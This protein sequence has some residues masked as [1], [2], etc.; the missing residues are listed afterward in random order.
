MN[1]QI[2]PVFTSYDVLQY[3]LTA[4]YYD[5][6]IKGSFYKHVFIAGG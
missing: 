4:K 3:Q 6:L 1:P 2:L 5:E